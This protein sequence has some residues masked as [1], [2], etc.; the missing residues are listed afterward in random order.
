MKRSL[1]FILRKAPYLSPHGLEAI[2]A[3]LVAG[4]FDQQV[5]VLFCGDSIWHLLKHQNGDEIGQRTMGK[6]ISALPEYDVS[7]LYVCADSMNARNLQADDFVV[8]I[9]VLDVS[10]QQQLIASQHAVLN[11]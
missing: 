3:M 6:V 9:Q 5:S 7:D 4:V 10:A 11:D 1:L 8:P 2:E